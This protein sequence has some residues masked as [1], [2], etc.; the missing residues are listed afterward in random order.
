L[1]SG[2]GVTSTYAYIVDEGTMWNDDDERVQSLIAYVDGVEVFYET[3]PIDGVIDDDVIDKL[4]SL[5]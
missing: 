4:Q 5:N 2:L 3:K 1:L